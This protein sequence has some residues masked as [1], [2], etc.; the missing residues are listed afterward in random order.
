[1]YLF[2]PMLIVSGKKVNSDIQKKKHE[3]QMRYNEKLILLL[4]YIHNYSTMVNN[5]IKIDIKLTCICFG[6]L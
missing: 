6:K 5:F 4:Q 3:V 1:M 2:L